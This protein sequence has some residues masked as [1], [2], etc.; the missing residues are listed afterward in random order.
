MSRVPL[1]I[2]QKLREPERLAGLI[3]GLKGRT[4]LAE[5]HPVADVAEMMITSTATN[6]YLEKI[7]AEAVGGVHSTEKLG[8][9]GYIG[10]DGLEIKPRKGKMGEK[11][12]GVIND[13]TPMK[14]LKDSNEI[15]WIVF[16][17]AEKDGS[18]INYAVVAPFHYWNADRFT[19][20]TKRLELE[21]A[22]D[23]C[24]GCIF[25]ETLEE[26]ARCLAE[27]QKRHKER[28]YVR[29][30]PLSLEVLRRI[31]ADERHIWV[32]PDVVSK[33]LPACVRESI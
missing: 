11:T 18:R 31:P 24:W 25:P 4:D 30:S 32:H 1:F 13:D 26:R 27:L 3:R 16:L 6:D 15:K 29:S 12:G 20:I 8:P 17:N 5:Y 7:G 9:D 33:N 10:S 28:T 22:S 2:V 19:Q 21:R 23:W 14:L